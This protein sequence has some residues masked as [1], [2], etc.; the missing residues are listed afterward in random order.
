MEDF[1]AGKTNVSPLTGQPMR[2]RD[3]DQLR[4]MLTTSAGEPVG[5]AFTSHPLEGR[6]RQP[7]RKATLTHAMKVL[8]RLL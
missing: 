1:I 4:A 2:Q 6:Q 8:N 5:A 3:A 7:V